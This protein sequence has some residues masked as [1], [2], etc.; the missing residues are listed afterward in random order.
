M[1]ETVDTTQRCADCG[2]PVGVPTVVEDRREF[3][4]GRDGPA[5]V[6]QSCYRSMISRDGRE[7]VSLYRADGVQRV[8]LDDRNRDRNGNR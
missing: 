5:T 1:T 3:P 2:R 7:V 6:C 4:T 8:V